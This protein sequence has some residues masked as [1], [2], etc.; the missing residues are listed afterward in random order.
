VPEKAHRTALAEKV[1]P[2]D[3]QPGKNEVAADE[4]AAV[5]V[6]VDVVGKKRLLS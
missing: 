4:V 5:V 6:A 2:N 1:F 3:P